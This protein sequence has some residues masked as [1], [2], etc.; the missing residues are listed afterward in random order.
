MCVSTG[1]AGWPKACDITTE[2]VLWPTPGSSSKS[3]KLSGTLPLCFVVNIFDNP[4]IAFDLLGESPHGRIISLIS[5]T[6]FS[7]ISQGLSASSKKAG[8]TWFTL[9]SVHWADNNTATSKVY[10]SLWSKG[11]S[12][13]GYSDSNLLITNSTFS[14]F[15]IAQTK[16]KE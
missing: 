15:F 16:L 3:L 9:L 13:L 2:A 5:S 6:S 12:I 4:L 7:C 11:I 10:G 1:K 8:V 14:D